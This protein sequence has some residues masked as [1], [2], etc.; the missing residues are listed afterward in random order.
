MLILGLM[1]ELIGE[2][3]AELTAGLQQGYSR[4]LA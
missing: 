1:L 4:A 2:T 3:K